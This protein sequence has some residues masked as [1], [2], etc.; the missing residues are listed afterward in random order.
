MSADLDFQT[1]KAERDGLLD[2]VSAANQRMHRE[3]AEAHTRRERDITAAHDNYHHA[4]KEASRKCDLAIIAA[5]AEP[6]ARALND[7]M[8]STHAT[9]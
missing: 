8:E 9:A 2:P 4:M 3:I 1:R 6:V 5:R 7:A